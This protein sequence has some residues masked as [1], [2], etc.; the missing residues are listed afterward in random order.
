MII[1]KGFKEEDVLWDPDV[2]ETE[3]QVVERA[4]LVLEVIFEHDDPCE[5]NSFL[6]TFCS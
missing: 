5:P 3:E 6:F 4:K 2:R 1:E